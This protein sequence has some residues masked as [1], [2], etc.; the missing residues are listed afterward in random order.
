MALDAILREYI[1]TR[2]HQDATMLV[3]L[4]GRVRA[5]VPSRL[6]HSQQ[7]P[8]SLYRETYAVIGVQPE[9]FEPDFAVYTGKLLREAHALDPNSQRSF[10]LYSTL[11]DVD[12]ES[13]NGVPSAKAA[14]AYLREFPRGPFALEAHFA[15]GALESDLFQV[16]NLWPSV[17]RQAS[18]VDCY[19]GMRTK[20]PLAQ[21][22]ERV[23]ASAIS[24]FRI[25]TRL[26]PDVAEFAFGLE[27]LLKRR[28]VV[29]YYC[30]D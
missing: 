19:A 15:L 5:I 13:S 2:A 30:A 26:R 9:L 8:T 25:L 29:W 18:K 16:L 22:R 4:D 24:H 11:F 3:R 12:G 10:T 6:W 21:Q 1:A 17:A 23:R 20:E 28:D 7:F 14:E 27:N